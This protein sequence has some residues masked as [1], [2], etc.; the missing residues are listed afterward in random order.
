MTLGSLYHHRER[1][2]AG[3]SKNRQAPY[4]W[5]MALAFHATRR[6]MLILAQ[7]IRDRQT[8]YVLAVKRNQPR[9]KEAIDDFFALFQS[10]SADLI[11]LSGG[12]H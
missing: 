10:A 9:L 5:R 3:Q 2:G 1:G 6:P 4:V 8:D 12:G 7:A 11:I